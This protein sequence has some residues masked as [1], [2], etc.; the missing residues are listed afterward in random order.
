MSEVSDRLRAFIDARG[1]SYGDLASITKIPKSAIQRYA[2]GQTE[3]IPID[4]VILLANAL[5][6]TPQAILGWDIAPDKPLPPN[7]Q[8][9]P[10]MKKVPRLGVI[11]CGEPILAEEN[12]EGYDSIPEYVTADFTL[13]CHGDS[14]IGA[15]IHDGDIVCIK[16]CEVVEDGQIAAILI[17]DEATLKRVYTYS[18]HIVLQPENPNYKPLSYWEEDMNRVHIMGLATHFISVVR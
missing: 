2:T 13:T 10:K 1:L 8:P 7:L 12:I 18:D 5:N 11:A 9:L 15:R 4:R 17:D 6:T 3:K 16:Q 14:M